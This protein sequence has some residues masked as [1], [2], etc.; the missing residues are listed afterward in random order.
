MMKDGTVNLLIFF[1]DDCIEEFAELE[2]LEIEE[3]T[4]ESIMERMETANPDKLFR[5]CCDKLINL[6][7]VKYVKCERNEV[8]EDCDDCDEENDELN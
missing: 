3:E 7:A 2:L 1:H 5:I 6:R 8:C 4:A